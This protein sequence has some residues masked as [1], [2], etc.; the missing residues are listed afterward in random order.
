VMS[1]WM[2]SPSHKRNIVN[3]QFRNIGIGYV[4]SGNYWVQDFGY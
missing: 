3:C 4:K 2:H 1:A